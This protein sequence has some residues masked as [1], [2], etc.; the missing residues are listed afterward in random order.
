[1]LTLVMGNTHYSVVTVLTAFM[2]GLALGSFLGGRFIDQKGRPLMVYAVLEVC[3]GVYCFFIPVIIQ[4]AFP[5]L[6]WMYAGYHESPLQLGFLRFLVCGGILLVPTAFMGATLPALS[7]FVSSRFEFIAR[8]V[9]ALYAVNTFGAVLGAMSSAFILMPWLGLQGSITLAAGINAA[10]AAAIFLF[11]P[12]RRDCFRE[13][14]LVEQSWAEPEEKSWNRTLVL[15][16]FGFSGVSALIYQVAWNRIF[17]LVLGSSV[18]AFSLIVTT[19]IFGIALGAAVFSRWSDT[20]GDLMKT[21][22]FLQAGIGMSALLVLP[23]FGFVPLLNR[24]IYQN[25]GVD[26]A[27]LQWTNFLIIFSFFFV[28]TFLMG[29]QFPLALKLVSGSLARVGRNV[30]LVYAFNTVGAIFGAFIGGFILIP[31]VGIQNSIL[32][33][34]VLNVGLG[35]LLLSQASS[36]SLNLKIYALPLALILCLWGV[37]SVPAWDKA[38]ITS[39]SFMPY[40]IDDLEEALRKNNKILF[41]REG[42]HTTVTTE[43]AVSGNIFLRVNGKTDAS[44]ALD[45]RTQLLSGYLPLFFHEK[46]DS[47]LVIGLGSGITLG[48]VEQ[49]PVQ[50][51][52]LVEISPAVIEGARFFAPFN[53]D[54]LKDERVNLIAEDGRSHVTFTDR[55]YDV[56][57]SEP[58]NP[59]ISGVGT[60]F[61]LEFFNRVKKKLNP[62][63]IVC[64]WVHTNMSPSNFKSVVRTFAAAFHYVTMWESIIG[65]DY[66][67]LGSNE[68]YRLPYRKVEDY[69]TDSSRN[70]DLSK[71]GVRSVRDLMS[72]MITS[73]SGLKEFSGDAPLHTDDN[74]LLEFQA[75]RYIY[76]D[77]RDVLVRQIAPFFKIDPDYLDVSA[78]EGETRARILRDIVS[79]ERSA[80]QV[81]DIKRRAHI[82]RLLDSAQKAFNRGSYEKALAHYSEILK[83]NPDEVMTHLNMGNVFSAMERYDQAELAYKKSVAINPFYVFGYIGLAKLYITMGQASKASRILREVSEWHPDDPET[84]VYLGLAFSLEKEPEKARNEFEK[85][86]SL[87]PEFALAHYYLAIHYWKRKPRLAKRHLTLFLQ[88][89]DIESSEEPLVIKAKKLLA[90]I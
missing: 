87:D 90:K 24:W 55:M 61:T 84:R 9:G 56:I 78:F 19:F 18:Y 32:C 72:L 70:T 73:T 76:K 80:S 25:M 37:R 51:I 20:C 27:V 60:L 45:M 23:W 14:E 69:L 2:G 6:K 5:V 34:I 7:K 54:A 33:A 16:V 59:W 38:V 36:V 48:A 30:G 28:P 10:I 31:W 67:L 8:D 62:K 39:G 53:H 68:P 79:A 88:L 13:R 58:S 74:L 85:A 40:R 52:D 64:I 89:A 21:F 49:F 66:L 41:Y 71:I 12:Y 86:V 11:F 83:L 75:P 47:V 26:F 63:G 81:E 44:L 29:G 42:I 35:L 15:W 22:G 57:I 82:E 50:E 77:E 43:L 3:I 4:A 65:D 1:M 17:S 46:P